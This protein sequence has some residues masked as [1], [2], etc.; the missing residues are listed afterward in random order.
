MIITL[1]RCPVCGSNELKAIKRRMDGEDIIYIYTCS[2]CDSQVFGKK[3]SI[4]IKESKNMISAQEIYNKSIGSILEIYANLGDDINAGTGVVLKDNYVITNAHVLGLS[5]YKKKDITQL[6]TCLA[7]KVKSEE[8]IQLDVIAVDR[9]LDLALLEATNKE[10]NSGIPICRDKVENAEK[11][12]AIGNAKGQGITIVDGLV[13]DKERI[14]NK[15]KY[16]LFSAPVNEGNSGGALINTKGELIG[17]VA[18]K[19]SDAIGMN[20][21]IPIDIVNKFID[22][23]I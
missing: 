4:S 8:K 14:L 15:N 5:N 7:S 1:D 9:E 6:T 16:I 21:A 2:S 12:Y 17:I 13:S 11:I 20:Y 19:R 22:D 3:S 10:L 23:N 18:L